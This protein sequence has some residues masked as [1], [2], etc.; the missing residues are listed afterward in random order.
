MRQ[1]TELIRR[2]SQV[3]SESKESSCLHDVVV[4]STEIA[5]RKGDCTCE[6]DLH[7][8]AAARRAQTKPTLAIVRP[9]VRTINDAGKVSKGLYKRRSKK[10]AQAENFGN[11]DVALVAPEKDKL[12]TPM[13]FHHLKQ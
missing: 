13:I 10:R 2:A 4:G 5:H 8:Q 6:N 3:E 11:F 7:G 9:Q 1:T 12:K